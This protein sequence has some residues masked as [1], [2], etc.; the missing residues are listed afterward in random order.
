MRTEKITVPLAHYNRLCQ[1]EIDAIHLREE[2]A[3]LTKQIHNLKY[4]EDCV[5]ARD[6]EPIDLSKAALI[7]AR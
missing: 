3:D 1:E 5:D 4:G 7:F 2:I 6:R